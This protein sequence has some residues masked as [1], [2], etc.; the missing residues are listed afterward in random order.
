MSPQTHKQEFK[1]KTNAAQIKDLTRKLN[2]FRARS[3]ETTKLME[4][5]VV[6]Y[7]KNNQELEKQLMKIARS[8]LKAIHAI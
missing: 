3:Q 7:L 8:A 2:D 6:G 4:K 5:L 1:V